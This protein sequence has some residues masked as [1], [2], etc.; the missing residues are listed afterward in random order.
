M[1]SP[2]KYHLDV[3]RD[4]AGNRDHRNHLRDRCLRNRRFRNETLA[5]CKSDILFWVNSFVY[6]FNPGHVGSE[7]GRFI[8]WP[9]QEN[10]LIGG[11]VDG[12]HSWGVLECVEDREDVRWQ[13]SREVGA[14]WL[15]LMAIDWLSLFHDR[16]KCLVLSRDKDAVDRFDDPDCLFWKLDFLHQHLP[17]WMTGEIKRKMLNFK[18]ERTQSTI[19]GEANV[20]SAGV[21]GRATMMLVDEFGQFEKGE[22]TYSMTSDTSYCRVFV[23]T[24]KN[25]AGMAYDLCFDPKY[26]T[27]REI[28]THWSQ[29]PEKNRGLYKYNEQRNAVEVLDKTFDYQTTFHFVMQGKPTGGPFPALR[30]PWYDK[31]CIRR[32]E[33]DVCMNLDIDP[34]GSSDIFFQDTYR[35]AVLK[36]RHCRPPSWTGDLQFDKSR[37]QFEPVLV[38]NQ[39]GKLKLWINP[40]SEI[41][42]PRFRAGAGVDVSAGTGMTPS[43]LSVIKATGQREHRPHRLRHVLRDVLAHDF[44]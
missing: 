1:L 35:L 37:H 14:S 5:K 10:A 3:P 39:K 24:H 20:I 22:E 32:T 34:Q 30:S 13:K 31:E 16:K 17:D 11:E 6:Q 38:P 19:N 18:F 25:K 12:K 7:V 41:L 15:V 44:G 40:A 8:T 2:G 29:H 42:L 27:M 26:S 21:G 4:Q 36:S 23:F 33:R 43:C 9:F 28:V